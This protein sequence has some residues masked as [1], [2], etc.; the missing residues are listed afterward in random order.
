MHTIPGSRSA[1]ALATVIAALAS[2]VAVSPAAWAAGPADLALDKA[3]PSTVASDSNLTYSFAVTNTSSNPGTSVDVKDT[4]PFG[5]T[6]VSAVGP[7]FTFTTPAVGG[8]GDVHATM[9]TLSGG[10]V[11][12]FSLTVHVTTAIG[13]GNL[14][15]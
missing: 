1:V 15:T 4:L 13:V 11:A 10:T 2:F 12:T 9:P 14:I 6:F 5:T 8:T 3:A 7:A